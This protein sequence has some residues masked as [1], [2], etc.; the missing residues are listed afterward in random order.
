MFYGSRNGVIEY[1]QG[2]LFT[3]EN[4][5]NRIVLTVC[6]SKNYH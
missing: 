5:Q 4:K 3:I 1:R 2:G 6:L